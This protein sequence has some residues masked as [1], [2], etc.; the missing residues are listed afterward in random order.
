[1]HSRAVTRYRL[2]LEYDGADFAGW[3]VQP[4]VRTVQ[5]CLQNAVLQL[6]GEPT[7]VM[8]A[9]RTDTGVHALGQVAHFTVHRERP[10][11]VITK[12][13]NSLLPPDVR[14]T[15]TRIADDRFHAR[16]SAQWRA[17]RYRIAL[18]PLAVGRSYSW[19]CPFRL[20]PV[21]MQRAAGLI[22]GERVF[23][24]FAHE[25]EKELHYLSTV[26]HAEWRE[27]GPHLEFRIAA[28]RFLHGMVR[29]LVGTFVEVGRGRRD[30]QD[31]ERILL[32]EDV[33]QAGPK[34]PAHGL[35]L[36]AVGYESWSEEVRARL[37]RVWRSYV[38]VP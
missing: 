14:I 33:R 13:L 18:R 7:V 3:Q 34:A 8:A 32:A 38:E 12:A 28:N 19:W 37:E 25:S 9:G 35:T 29:L 21:P 6:F 23:R 1:M 5:G 22:V 31:I 10:P 36:M 20:D 26:H 2:N 4:D 30:P 17:Y 15:D 16:Y 11:E 24:S 27:H